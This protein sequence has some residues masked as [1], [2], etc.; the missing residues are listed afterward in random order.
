MATNICEIADRCEG[1]IGCNEDLLLADRI[2]QGDLAA[3]S[4]LE[5]SLKKRGWVLLQLNDSLRRTVAALLAGTQ[6]FWSSPEALQSK[7]CD[8]SGSI[9]WARKADRETVRVLTG[10]ML[11][12][13]TGIVPSELRGLVELG[14]LLD[15]LCYQLISV[16]ALPVFGLSVEELRCRS[17][18]P[19]LGLCMEPRGNYHGMLDIARYLPTGDRPVSVAPHA[20]PG[21]FALSLVSTEPG[22]QVF[23]PCCGVWV[24]PPVGS[25]VLWLGGTAC[26]VA[27]GLPVGVHR[28]VR[29][30]G[31]RPR[32]TIWYEVCAD[33][34]VPRALRE[35]GLCFTEASPSAESVPQTGGSIQ[36][37]VRTLAGRKIPIMVTP[38]TDVQTVKTLLEEEEGIPTQKLRFACNGELLLDS[39]PL[40]DYHIKQGSTLH[41]ALTLRGGMQI[42]VKT[43]TGKT[44][45]LDIEPSDTIDN[46]KA[47]IQD[48]EGIPPS[49]QRLIFAG[50]QLEDGRTLSDY[51]IQKESTLHLVLRLR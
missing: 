14:N 27:E 17:A 24:A 28:V 39:R 22:L 1:V 29:P 26:E 51:N 13:M 45:T 10:A 48:K 38:D 47:K 4:I 36:I 43:L 35:K 19:L 34:Q 42:F 40:R 32:D 44:I 11:Q 25:A 7:F 18:L 33:D 49:K 5:S 15:G 30:S 50:K 9:G 37:S 8:A 23:D 31:T 12:D 2:C 41:M 16:M 21:L 20:D 6:D 3:L 46:V